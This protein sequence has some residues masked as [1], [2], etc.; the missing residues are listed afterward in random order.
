MGC[1]RRAGEQP[2]QLPNQYRLDAEDGG[3][4]MVENARRTNID[5]ED[6]RVL[7]VEKGKDWDEGLKGWWREILRTDAGLALIKHLTQQEQAAL[8]SVASHDFTTDEGVK[9]ALLT[10]GRGQGISTT[11]DVLFDLA[12]GDFDV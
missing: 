9:K 5:R 10:K 12:E 11:I 2:A 7:A 3:A 6:Y 4:G 1:L 8:I